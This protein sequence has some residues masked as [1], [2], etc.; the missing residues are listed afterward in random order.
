MR[1]SRLLHA[2][3]LGALLA[4]AACSGGSPLESTGLRSP[5]EDIGGLVSMSNSRDQSPKLVYCDP[6]PEARKTATIGILGGTIKVGPHSVWI[7]PGA[8]LSPK[9]ITAKIVKNDYTNSVQLFPEG[10]E[11]NVP[12]MLTLSY[13][14]CSKRYL[15]KPLQVVYTSDDLRRILELLPSINNPIEKST[16]GTIRHFSRY[17]VAF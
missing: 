15:L 9:S 14:N 10:L 2:S 6:F 8:L 11:F 1:T 13:A 12:A 3:M 7:P 5:A 4:V 16:V 17:A